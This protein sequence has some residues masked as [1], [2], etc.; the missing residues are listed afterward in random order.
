MNPVPLPIP[1]HLAAELTTHVALVV[2]IYCRLLPD[3]DQKDVE[4]DALTALVERW[5]TSGPPHQPFSWLV[6][7]IH[8]L[9]ARRCRVRWRD[10]GHVSLSPSAGPQH[11][12]PTAIELACHADLWTELAQLLDEVVPPLSEADKVELL[13]FASGESRRDLA[14]DCGESVRTVERRL[15]R[16]L[17]RVAFFATRGKSRDGDP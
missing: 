13:A 16:N 5:R 15:K 3:H 14:R 11:D 6:A 17:E 2:R 7:V 9:H 8:K 12:A 1:P 4:Q 10:R